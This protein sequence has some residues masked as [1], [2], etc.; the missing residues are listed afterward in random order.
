MTCGIAYSNLPRNTPVVLTEIENL[1]A[2]TIGLDAASV[3]LAAIER[4]LQL[5]MTAC[6][7][8]SQSAYLEKI[9]SSATELQELIEVVVVSET[10]F[11]RDQEAFA[12]LGDFVIHEWLPARSSSKLRL[13]SIPCATGEEAYSMAMTLDGIGLSADSFQI[14]AVDISEHALVRARKAT[15]SGNSFRGKNLDFRDRYFESGPHGYRLSDA[16]RKRVL[17]QQGNLLRPDFFPGSNH[18]HF[19]FC[20]NLLIYLNLSA[21]TLA[22]QTLK[23]LLTPD[24]LLF[25]GPAEAALMVNHHLVSA[26]RPMAFAFRHGALLPE[27]PPDEK[28]MLRLK[29]PPVAL[30]LPVAKP[31]PHVKTQR[32]ALT[33]ATPALSGKMGIDLKLASQF[34]DEGRLEEAVKVCET[35]LKRHPS[36]VEALYLLGVIYDATGDWEK[37][38]PYYRKALYLD[39]EH[40]DSLMHL[41]YAAEKE[42][43]AVTVQNLRARANRVKERMQHA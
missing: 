29:R 24:G 26:K 5:R 9:Q 42:G 34:A 36:S 18:F 31:K 7:L 8:K 6:G 11:F 1:L 39:P 12:V 38:R 3:G 22:V 13:L 33:Q 30:P 17:F 16:V 41:A 19:I 21:Q 40:Y 10:W 25:V 15:Y 14:D 2:Q 4:A 43:D 23:R 20:R 32:V 27:K 28:K 37:A 35:Y